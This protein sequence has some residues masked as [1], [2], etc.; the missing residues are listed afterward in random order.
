[1]KT[2]TKCGETKDESEFGKRRNECKKCFAL[3]MREY[4]IENFEKLNEKRKTYRVENS[5]KIKERAIKYRVENSEI[6][7][8][9]EKNNRYKLNDTYIKRK[10]IT[11]FNIPY[12]EISPE[13]IKLKRIE[14]ENKRLIKTLK[15]NET[16]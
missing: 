3:R 16:K 5:E 14:L 8:E 2:C 9:K 6:I 4:R 10:I 7:K 13:L 12:S 1:M 15:E 11:K